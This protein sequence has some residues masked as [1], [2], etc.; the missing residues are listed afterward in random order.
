MSRVLTFA[1]LL[2]LAFAIWLGLTVEGDPHSPAPIH[3]IGVVGALAASIFFGMIA[4]LIQY[5]RVL[6][7]RIVLLLP[8]VAVSGLFVADIAMMVDQL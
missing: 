4:A 2:M 6:W 7:V 3:L 5:W 8:V 1:A